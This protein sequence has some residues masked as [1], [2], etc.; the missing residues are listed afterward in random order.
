MVALV[1]LLLALATSAS[2]CLIGMRR[3]G[4]RPADLGRAATQALECVGLAMAFLI[5]N[6]AIGA[7]VILATRGLTGQF[8]SVYLVRD[9]TLVLVSGLQGLLFWTWWRGPR[10]TSSRGGDPPR[11]GAGG[12]PR[13]GGGS[14]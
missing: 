2:A 5:A 11:G 13:S 1:M 3:L 4:L 12:R 7:G 8:V 10:S 9:D 14:R 6:V